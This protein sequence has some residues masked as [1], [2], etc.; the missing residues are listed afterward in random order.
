MN[1]MNRVLDRPDR[2]GAISTSEEQAQGSH[3][4]NRYAMR[5]MSMSESESVLL[6]RDSGLDS[7]KT[8]GVWAMLN[9]GSP[10]RS[11]L[12]EQ[13]TPDSNLRMYVD[14]GLTNIPS[15]MMEISLSSKGVAALRYRRQLR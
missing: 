4:M 15:W 1:V 11:R 14:K 3:T 6:H 2:R 9:F 12:L 7:V 8:R 13:D 10:D 5:N